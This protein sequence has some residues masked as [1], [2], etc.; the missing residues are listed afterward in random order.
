MIAVTPEA[1]STVNAGDSV[2]LTVSRGLDFGGSAEVPSVVG[3]S[4]DDALTTLGKWTDIEVV[5]EQ[6]SEIPAGEVISQSLEAYSSADPDEPITITVSSGDQAP[7]T[8]EESTGT[9]TSSTAQQN[10]TAAANG[11]VWKCTQTLNTPQGYQG[12]ALRLELVQESNG[13]TESTNIVDGQAL[14]FPYQLDIT[15]IPGVSQGTL[16]VYELIDGSFQ[17]LGSYPLTFEKAE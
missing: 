7:G 14:E 17:Q 11:E 9:E 4:E 15:G 10:N 16:Y 1:G 13:E 5:E 3:M 8:A 6:N 2:T 12:G